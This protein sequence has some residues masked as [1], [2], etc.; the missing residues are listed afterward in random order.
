[1]KLSLFSPREEQILKVLQER[2]KSIAQIV[3]LINSREKDS[4]NNNVIANSVRRINQKCEYHNLPWFLNGAG[5]G[6]AGRTV[7]KDKR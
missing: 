3:E 2:K 1:M 6:R 5:G 7:W 4:C